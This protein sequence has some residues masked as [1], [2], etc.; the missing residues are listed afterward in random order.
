MELKNIETVQSLSLELE[1][2]VRQSKYIANNNVEFE[3]QVVVKDKGIL[4]VD[5]GP[6]NRAIALSLFR[7]RV[8]DLVQTLRDLG[9]VLEEPSMPELDAAIATIVGNYKVTVQA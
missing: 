4:A 8:I 7:R 6:A 5:L 3:Q 2:L 1:R 9:V